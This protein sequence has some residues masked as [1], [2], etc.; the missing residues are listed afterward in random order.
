M[1]YI[2]EHCLSS[3]DIRFD[4]S[5]VPWR[6]DLKFYLLCSCHLVLGQQDDA[7]CCYK[8]CLDSIMVCLDRKAYYWSIWWPT[9]CWGTIYY[10][11]F[12]C[13]CARTCNS[14]RVS[15]LPICHVSMCVYIYMLIN[16]HS[17][18]LNFCNS[19]YGDYCRGLNQVYIFVVQIHLLIL[20]PWNHNMTSFSHIHT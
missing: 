17:R 7:L 10:I 1:F 12:W 16:E 15:V 19:R 13:V 8:K 3:T 14:I 11:P 9:K 4:K 20:S 2:F 6:F 18:L 5:V